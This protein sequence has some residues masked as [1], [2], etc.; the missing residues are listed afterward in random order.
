MSLLY[1]LVVIVIRAKYMV[2]PEVPVQ[3]VKIT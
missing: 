1:T 3:I 2:L